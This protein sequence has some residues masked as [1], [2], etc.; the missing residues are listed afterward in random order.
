[1]DEFLGACMAFG[2]V[3]ACGAAILFAATT[4]TEQDQKHFL[5]KRA[6]CF[7]ATKSKDCFAEVKEK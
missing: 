2:L 3:T 4:C 5:A 7:E 1:M 6:Q